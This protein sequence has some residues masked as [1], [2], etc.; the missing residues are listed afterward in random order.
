MTNLFIGNL[1]SLTIPLFP[2]RE[3]DRVRGVCFSIK[4]NWGMIWFQKF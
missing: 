1:L 4:D 2:Q 3:R